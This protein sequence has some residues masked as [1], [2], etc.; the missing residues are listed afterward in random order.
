MT[1]QWTAPVAVRAYVA[2]HEKRPRRK[3]EPETSPLRIFLDFETTVDECQAL[4][5]GSFEV[6]LGKRLIREGLVIADESDAPDRAIIELYSAGHGDADGGPLPV[7]TRSEFVEEVIWRVG[8]R[9]RALIVGFNLAFDLSRLALGQTRSKNGGFSLPL[10]ESRDAAGKGWPHMW[11]PSITIKHVGSK[12]QFI[13]FTTPAR[14]DPE[15]RVDGAGYRGR[16]LDLRMAA[17]ALTDRSHSLASASAEFDIQSSKGDPGV[18]GVVTPDYIDYNRQDVRVT[19]ELYDALEAEWQRHPIETPLGQLYSGATVGKR[20]LEA[21]GV[22]PPRGKALNIGNEV[23]GLHMTAYYGGRAECRVRR[24]PLPVRYLDVTSMYPTV[25]ALLGLWQYVIARE[26]VSVDATEEAGSW[27]DEVARE[28][29]HEPALWPALACTICRVR[30]DG[31]LLPV[32]SLYGA[33]AAWTIGLNFLSTDEDMWFTLADLAVCKLLSGLTPEILEATRVVPAGRQRGLH[34]VALRNTVTVDPA[35]DD[36]F[37]VVIESRQR[38]KRDEHLSARERKRLDRFLKV[39]AN[40]TSYGVFAEF[41]VTEPVKGGERV[42]AYGLGRL[43][44]RVT[45]PEEP[46][47]YCFPPLAATIT[48]AARLLL[49]LLEADVTAIGGTYAGTDTDAMLVVAQPAGGLVACPGGAERLPDGREAVLA[50]SDAQVEDVRGQL[51]ALNPYAR[52]A[53]PDL[54]KLEVENLSTDGSSELVNLYAVQIS[55]KRYAL[56]E[57]LGDAIA[58]RKV[59]EHGLGLFRAP[60]SRDIENW[61]QVVWERILREAE[62]M[63]VPPEPEWFDRP[64]VSQ[65]AISSPAL[66]AP[67]ARV[68]AHRQKFRDR[69]KA[70]NFMLIGHPDRLAPVPS[71]LRADQLTPV[72]PYTSNPEEYLTQKWFNRHDGR[73]IEVTTNPKGEPGKVRLKTYRD[74]VDEYATHPENKSGDPRGGP[75]TRGSVGLLPRLHVAATEIRHIGKESNRLDEV[76]EGVVSDP[77]EVYTEYRDERREWVMAVPALRKLRQELGWRDLAAASGLSERALR[78]AL[79][80]ARLPRAAARA[81]L[82]SLRAVVLAGAT[83]CA[84]CRRP[85]SEVGRLTAGHIRPIRSDLAAAVDPSGLAPQCRSC[86]EFEKHRRNGGRT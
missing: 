7:M 68:N 18:H 77:D 23:L 58:L 2:P 40:A 38:L 34:P 64:A 75:A 62:S 44:A 31:N 6:R 9:G 17:F 1:Q 84:W 86:Q 25:F 33:D 49:A 73:V 29:L 76:E 67:F 15:N 56:Y 63:P 54:L 53:V 41:R 48:G 19:R 28:T 4:L 26:L 85:A 35:N 32:R 36:F 11:R 14:L 74:I 78:D 70:H 43:E 72:A 5:F 83:H 52:D 46:G 37:R 80:R 61:Y 79:N 24:T 13:S 47:V 81:R 50:L 27:L 39:I 55:A 16:F 60:V 69:I 22:R 12:R 45:T 30:P 42:T 10:F 66:L 82:L 20:Y 3:R 8:Y 59:S 51:N 57:C 21:M 71:D 65:L